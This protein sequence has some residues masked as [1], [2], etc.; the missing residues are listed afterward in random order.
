MADHTLI[1]GQTGSGKTSLGVDLAGEFY[2]QGWGLL[3]LDPTFD[4]RWPKD[5]DRVFQTHEFGPFWSAFWQSRNCAVFIDE[6]GQSLNRWNVNMDKVATQG[7]HL[8]HVVHVLTQRGAQ[9]SRTIRDQMSHFYFFRTR[10]ADCKVFAEDL[11]NE[12][13][14]EANSLDDFE[15]IYSDLRGNA[16]K[17][18]LRRPT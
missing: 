9:V 12:G 16:R 7:R 4:S 15:Y 8:G 13:I 18:T 14:L 1:V 6:G 3:V 17:G 11:E 2:R 5:A 10:R